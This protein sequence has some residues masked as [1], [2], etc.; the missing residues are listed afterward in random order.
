MTMKER[1]DKVLGRFLEQ[2]KD[3]AVEVYINNAVTS[4][5]MGQVFIT[6]DRT[7]KAD[8][9]KFRIK[10]NIGQDINFNE[11]S[12]AYDEILACYDE[13]D[14]YDQQTV[15]VIFKNGM[16]FIFECIGMQI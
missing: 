5:R 15:Y 14:E 4:N 13:T 1:V 16:E 10:W 9:E 11:F 2:N 8:E 3:Y 7:V 12:F 6:M